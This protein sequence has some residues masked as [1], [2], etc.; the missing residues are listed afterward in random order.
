MDSL[1]DVLSWASAGVATFASGLAA[2]VW[3]Q[4]NKRIDAIEQRQEQ[5]RV[6]TRESLKSIFEKLSDQGES[7]A[8]IEGKLSVKQNEPD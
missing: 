3:S 2:V 4:H 5:Q 8:R 6:E 1:S 7:L